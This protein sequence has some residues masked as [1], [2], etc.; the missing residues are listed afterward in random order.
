MLMRVFC[1]DIGSGSTDAI[2]RDDSGRF[3]AAS[4]CGIP[5]ISDPSAAE[6]R[7]LRDGLTLA[8]QV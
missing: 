8:G 2:I 4:Y 1:A 5:F 3:I 6:A 7:A